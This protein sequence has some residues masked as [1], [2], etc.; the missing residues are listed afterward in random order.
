MGG[1][2]KWGGKRETL[3]LGGGGGCGAGVEGSGGVLGG[4]VEGE[5]EG[6]AGD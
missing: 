5:G 4:L 6:G 2:G 3:Q 1:E